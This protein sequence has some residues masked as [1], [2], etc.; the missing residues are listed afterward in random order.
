MM[1]LQTHVIMCTSLDFCLHMGFKLV[2]FGLAGRH[3]WGRYNDI[4]MWKWNAVLRFS[5]RT[6]SSGLCLGSAF[7]LF[8]RRLG[9]GVGTVSAT[10]VANDAFV[11]LL[12]QVVDVD[13]VVEHI[14]QIRIGS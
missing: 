1:I 3:F 5:A 7:F 10:F 13:S 6:L 4:D 11:L 9:V 8:L 14:C 2:Q 12:V